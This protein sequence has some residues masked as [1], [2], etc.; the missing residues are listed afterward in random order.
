MPSCDS[1]LGSPHSVDHTET[2]TSPITRRT[3]ALHLAQC[4]Y[5]QI[6]NNADY[7]YNQFGKI[8]VSV[9]PAHRQGFASPACLP[10][11]FLLIRS[12]QRKYAGWQFRP[13]RT[14]NLPFSDALM[15]RHNAGEQVVPYQ[16]LF[17][18]PLCRPTIRSN[19]LSRSID[20]KSIIAFSIYV[21]YSHCSNVP[22]QFPAVQSK[23]LPP[24]MI[25]AGAFYWIADSPYFSW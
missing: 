20:S 17:P 22:R 3:S 21:K 6:C 9:Y 12:S 24:R 16:K 14:T 2:L 18:Y 11:Y 19:R 1:G 23:K 15:S 13:I 5:L 8:P 4:V 7:K 10:A 25:S